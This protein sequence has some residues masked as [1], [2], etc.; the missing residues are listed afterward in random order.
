MASTQV[1]N[2]WVVPGDGWICL[3]LAASASPASLDGGGME[4]NTEAAAEAGRMVT[5]TSASANTLVVQGMVPDGVSE[6]TLTAA[7]GT[8]LTV[9]VSDN[10]YGA[11]LTGGELQSVRMGGPAG[12]LVYGS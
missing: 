8:S 10:L 4:C 6:V 7:D 5:W 2:V 9:P 12:E 3:D 1:G 11:N